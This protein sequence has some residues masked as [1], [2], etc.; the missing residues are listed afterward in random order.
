MYFEVGLAVFDR[1][2]DGKFFLIF[3]PSFSGYILALL[4]PLSI[5]GREISDKAFE[6]SGST[7]TKK[8]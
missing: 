5:A 3:V 1:S 4:S 8:Y 6:R 7:I 2:S